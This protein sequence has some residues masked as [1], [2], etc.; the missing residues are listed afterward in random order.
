MRNLTKNNIIM[1]SVFVALAVVFYKPFLSSV[2][3]MKLVRIRK[4]Y[5]NVMSTTETLKEIL[6][7][8][9]IARFGDGELQLI[10]GMGLVGE[11]D[12]SEY[13]V[14]NK[15]LSN[16][17]KEIV[18]SPTK[19][20]IVAINSFCDKWI[21]KKFDEEKFSWWET[22]WLTYWK[23]LKSI[24]KKGY[25]YGCAE[26]SRV[27]FFR[28]NDIKDI[29]KI[30]NKRKVL[31]VVGNGSRFVYEKRL[32]DNIKSAKMLVVAGKSSFGKY[33]IILNKIK[34]FDRE[35]LI[36]LSLGPCATV[37]AY[38]LSK[39]GYQALD[40]GHLP[41]SYLEAI[42]ER[43]KP[44]EELSEGRRFLMAEGIYDLNL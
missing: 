7:G 17:L 38:D 27:T 24:Y 20:C 22:F 12:K 35:Y 37:L 15:E 36:L 8:K 40:I 26:I 32:F 43:K 25:T 23:K 9:S 18:K 19:N 10:M 14:Y 42:G 29:K 44:E 34:T 2:Y 28:E 33:D 1:L 13:Q 21:D 41:N 11:G 31:F 4:E 3:A 30:W 39:E 6:S 5:P 16:R